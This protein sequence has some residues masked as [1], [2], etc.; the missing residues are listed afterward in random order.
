MK[1]A[2]IGSGSIASELKRR[3]E[4]QGD[5]VV[6]FVSRKGD[7]TDGSLKKWDDGPLH[8]NICKAVFAADPDIVFLTIST[9]DCG[10]AAKDYIKSFVTDFPVVT[11]EKGALAYYADELLPFFGK[12]GYSA[13]VGGGTHIINYVQARRLSKRKVEIHAVLNGTLNFIFD[14]VARGGGGLAEVCREAVRLGFAEPGTEDPI[15]LINGE[16]KDVHMKTCVFFNSLFGENGTISPHMFDGIRIAEEDVHALFGEEY[17][18]CVS[19]CR[20]SN[21]PEKERFFGHRSFGIKKGDWH[22]KGGFVSVGP[23]EEQ[24]LPSGV[25][26]AVHIIEGEF[27]SG[28]IYTL[29]G[30]GAGAEPT[31]TAMLNDAQLL[32]E[33]N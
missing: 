31:V 16:L 5:R 6:S 29:S 18:F 2:I 8:E 30:P 12:I 32:L 26:N 3:L 14:E 23:L 13:S 33:R 10:K 28:G 9:T 22:I 24:W 15:S 25:G 19:F 20:L 17:R 21:P 27:G 7:R 4:N 1:A 11:C